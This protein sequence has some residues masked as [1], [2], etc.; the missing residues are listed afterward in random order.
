MVPLARAFLDAGDDVLWATAAD[1]TARLER[2]GFRA[3]PAGLTQADGMAELA[4]RFPELESLPPP[5]RP[6][7]MFP[8]LFGS[9]RAAPMLDDLAP[10]ARAWSPGL[11]VNDAAELAGPVVAGAQG[12]A[13]ATHAFGAL[14]PEP[15][16]A[17]AG[18][19]VAPLWTANGLE[20][21]PYGG[22]YDHL[23]LDIYP[24]SL[25]PAERPHVP[26]TQ[27]LR[28][29]AF[30]TAGDEA[31]PDWASERSGSPL[32]YV[33]FGTVFSNHEALSTVVEAVGRLPVRVVVTV[34]PHG[35]PA[36][37]GRQPANVHVAR[38]IPQEQLLAHCAAVV[39]H[40]GSGTF[41]AALAAGLPQLCLPQAADQFLNAAACARAQVGLTIEPG[42]VS[43][44][45]VADA[46]E[47]LLSDAAFPAAAQRGGD[48]IAA[49]PP[50]AEV[51]ARLHADY[52]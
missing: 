10:V 27:A 42:R 2:E 24:P 40:G 52:A 7:S 28:P 51:A 25:Q 32:V 31:L 8:R 5:E 11:V 36:S 37:L 20:P 19:E 9:V 4:R 3:V 44:D 29:G 48:E 43:V 17:A 13:N 16:V 26:A 18:R 49:M 1:V 33:T 6:D 38:Y 46:V 41:L 39:S 34:G 12:V 15:R 22:S 35:D 50:A 23:Y 30:A 14:L 21:R 45:R 47:R